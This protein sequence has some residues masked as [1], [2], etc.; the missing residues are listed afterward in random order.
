MAENLYQEA[1][2]SLTAIGDNTRLFTTEAKGFLKEQAQTKGFEEQ[3]GN[4]TALLKSLADLVI[5]RRN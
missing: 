5:K 4:N 1:M 2:V 3:A